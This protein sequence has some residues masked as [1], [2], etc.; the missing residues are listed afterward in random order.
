MS[1]KTLPIVSI[2]CPH[3]GRHTDLRIA[4][5]TVKTY[6]SKKTEYNVN[7]VWAKNDNEYWWMGICNSC[8]NPLLIYNDGST[9][10]PFPLPSPTDTRIPE[11]IRK[12]LDEAKKC[13]NIGASRACA[14][15]A[16]RAIQATC[17]DKGASKNKDLVGQINELKEKGVITE[18][19]KDWAHTVRWVANDAAH[20]NKD[21]VSSEDS[22]SI[23]KL[24]EQFLHI[25]YVTSSIAKEIREKKG[26][27]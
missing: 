6:D 19:I 13:L 23:L 16:R 12:D 14:V 15:M 27:A 22:E 18:D 3:C 7:L 10:Y 8:Q 17:I 11:N 4:S 2:H 24:A 20:P 5:T 9:M 1:N 21:E 25:I 26:K